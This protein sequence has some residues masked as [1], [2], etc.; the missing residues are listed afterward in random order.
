MNLRRP[1]TILDIVEEHFDELDFL[2]ELREGNLFAPDWTLDD[3]KAHEERA[4]AHLDGLRG[5]ELHSVDL[6]AERIKGTETFM[7][8]AAALVLFETGESEYHH[9]ILEALRSADR[10][11]VEGIRFA[12]RHVDSRPFS[13]GL[14]RLLEEGEQYRAA[15][16]ADV[17]AFHQSPADGLE[18]LLGS[19][20]SE[21]RI[22]ALGAAAR[23]GRGFPQ[24]V[25]S[26]V[27]APDPLVRRA[28]LEAAVRLGVPGVHRHCRAAAARETDPDSI[29]VA[30]LG[31][32]G[33]PADLELLQ[34]LLSREDVARQAVYAL[35]AMGSVSAIPWLL[36]LM[37]DGPLAIPAAS[38]Y[39]RI[40]GEDTLPPDP[41]KARAD[42][43][44]REAMMTPDQTWQGG[45]PTP[46]EGFPLRDGR[47]SLA[48][49]RDLYLRTRAKGGSSVPVVELEALVHR[50]LST[51]S[52]G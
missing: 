23:L 7:A 40:T 30:F 51:G 20:D 49:R 35:G 10:P 31:V 24:E 38:A 27:E 9:L 8:T 42:W 43:K 18:I 25:A 4:E 12:L 3:L 46:T 2:W 19:D 47:F 36:E 41:E 33:D 28:A 48:A 22:L 11:T 13:D 26:A 37:E 14:G 39:G 17:L 45:L 44:G 32:L 1:P 50:Q 5:A 6:A 16:A 29:C 15:V 52:G 21:V 34:G